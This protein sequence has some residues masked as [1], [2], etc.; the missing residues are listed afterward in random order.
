MREIQA[1]FRHFRKHDREK[2]SFLSRDGTDLKASVP[3]VAAC[4]TRAVRGKQWLRVVGTAASAVAEGSGRVNC[5]YVPPHTNASACT[6]RNRGRG[7]GAPTLPRRRLESNR[8][9]PI[10]MVKSRPTAPVDQA[11]VHY[12]SA[13]RGTA[14]ITI[15]DNQKCLTKDVNQFGHDGIAKF[16]AKV[17]EAEKILSA[18]WTSSNFKAIFR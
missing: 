18:C 7:G 5:E 10:L 14:P 4:G 8:S 13:P 15:A 6:R 2:F 3:A 9:R 1:I 16:L 17:G 12:H 11:G